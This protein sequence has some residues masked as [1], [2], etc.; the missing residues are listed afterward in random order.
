[1]FLSAVAA[2]HHVRRFRA[3][4]VLVRPASVAVTAPA[5]RKRRWCL[6]PGVIHRHA[7]TT[8]LRG[9][10]VPSQRTRSA[11]QAR[12]RLLLMFS[13]MPQR[14]S[15]GWRA[16]ASGGISSRE[17]SREFSS[18]HS[19]YGADSMSKLLF[20][21]VAL[22]A[23]SALAFTTMATPA[24][25]LCDCCVDCNCPAGLCADGGCEVGGECCCDT[26]ACC[27]N[28]CSTENQAVETACESGCCKVKSM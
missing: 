9:R 18:E 2:L 13:T 7:V 22:V 5:V 11:L 21:A 14:C 1:M 17:C 6:R 26:G 4:P 28:G 15:A 10:R 19:S 27:V 16:C 23:S 24:A 8:V 12:G 25:A 3:R 20:S